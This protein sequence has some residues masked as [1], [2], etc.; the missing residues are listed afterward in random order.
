M[1]AIQIREE[2]CHHLVA[3]AMLL[4]LTSAQL[5]E[6]HTVYHKLQMQNCEEW[7][8]FEEVQK[9]TEPS[10]LATMLVSPVG[11]FYRQECGCYFQNVAYM[12][13]R[14]GIDHEFRAVEVGA[15]AASQVAKSYLG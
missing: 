9:F 6:L 15:V 8:F 13:V 10:R 2:L 5:V 12:E 4:D 7:K 11:S 14:P 3:L 1:A